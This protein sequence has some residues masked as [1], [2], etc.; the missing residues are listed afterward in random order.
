MKILILGAKGM[1]GT[2]VSSAFQ[3]H[4]PILKDKEDFD[5]TDFELAKNMIKEISPEIIINCTGYIDVEKAETEEDK[6]NLLNGYAV[7]NLAKVC[8]EIDATLIHMSTEYVFDGEKKEG[9]DENSMPNSKNAY[10]RSKALGEKLL[11]EVNCNHYIVRTSWL[12]GKN[13]QRGKERGVN[14]I[15]RIQELAKER[16]ELN[17]VNDQFSKPTFTFDLA[18]AL[19]KLIDEKFDFGIYHIVNEGVATPYELANAVFEKENI[20]TK[21]NPIS[22]SAYPSKVDRPINAILINTKFPKLRNWREAIKDYTS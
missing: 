12:F 18:N 15:E 2:D 16:D 20:K 10:G 22:Y 4:N 5:I 14:F 9:Y 13:M 6:A 19:K 8:K 17:M 7:E 1:L 11:Q 3:E 21:T